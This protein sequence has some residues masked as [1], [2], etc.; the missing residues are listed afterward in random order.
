MLRIAVPLTGLEVTTDLIEE[1]RRLMTDL[2]E[3]VRKLMTG[4]TKVAR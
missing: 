1:V 2:I 3:E 4:L